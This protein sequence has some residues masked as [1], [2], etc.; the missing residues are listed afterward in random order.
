MNADDYH[1]SQRKNSSSDKKGVKSIHIHTNEFFLTPSKSNT[2]SNKKKFNFPKP[3]YYSSMKK[4]NKNNINLKLSSMHKS[5]IKNRIFYERELNLLKNKNKKLDEETHKIMS[6]INNSENMKKLKEE[7]KIN[8]KNKQNFLSNLLKEKE[9]EMK[10]KKYKV[11]LMKSQEIERIKNIVIYRKINSE[12]LS[13]KKRILKKKI[14]QDISEEKNKINEEKKRKINL[15]K[16]VDND[17]FKRKKEIE[18]RKKLMEKKQLEQEIKIQEDF[19]K[20]LAIKICELKKIGLDKIDFLQRIK[21]K[22]EN[23]F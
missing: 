2:T 5:S 7:R 6:K 13:E 12:N 4:D 8:Y 14:L 15:I 10:E 17:I 22:L 21:L 19:N 9:K 16:I 11:K 18:K 3:K 23:K 20:K 1:L